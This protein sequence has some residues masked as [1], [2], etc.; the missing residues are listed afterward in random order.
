MPPQRQLVILNDEL[1]EDLQVAE[2][3]RGIGI[4][5]THIE[6]LET[7]LVVRHDNDVFCRRERVG[8][9]NLGRRGGR[10]NDFLFHFLL[11]NDFLLDHNGLNDRFLNYHLFL[12]GNY[13]WRGRRAG[14]QQ[15]D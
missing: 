15:R 7:I 1:L 14:R 2:V 12:D 3:G 11:Y 8:R 4:A 5:L 13:F 10:H 6:L 9:S